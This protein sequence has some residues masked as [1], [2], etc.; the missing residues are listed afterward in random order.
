MTSWP[1]TRIMD[2]CETQHVLSQRC[3]FTRGAWWWVCPECSHTTL[4][5]PLRSTYRTAPSEGA[6]RG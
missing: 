6:D 5:A 2:A 4:N 3:L 1:Q